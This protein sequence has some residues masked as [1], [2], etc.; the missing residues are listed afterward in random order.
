MRV[1]YENTRLTLRDSV[2]NARLSL[3]QATSAYNNALQIK[4]A[5]LTQMRVMRDNA[6]ITLAQARR[7]YAKLSIG[8]PVD[9]T[10]TR[11]RVGV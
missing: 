4:Q 11:L 10:V 5:T 9:G 6:S 7:D 1:T 2:E 3:D 8:A